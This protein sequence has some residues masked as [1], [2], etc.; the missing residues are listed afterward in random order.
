MR[1]IKKHLTALGGKSV[2]PVGKSCKMKSI[3][4]G[5]KKSPLLL[6]VGIFPYEK[7]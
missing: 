7:G 5:T 3:N 6:R 1:N 2:L 4:Q